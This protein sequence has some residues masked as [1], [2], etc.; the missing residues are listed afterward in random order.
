MNRKNLSMISA[1]LYT[2]LEFMYAHAHGYV[3]DDDTF[4]A[5][6]TKKEIIK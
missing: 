2:K 6:R 4:F 5:P 3:N 1:G